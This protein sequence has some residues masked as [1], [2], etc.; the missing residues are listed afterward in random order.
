[1]NLGGPSES[2]SAKHQVGYTPDSDVIKPLSSGHLELL[3]NSQAKRLI[4]TPNLP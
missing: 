2:V 3:K 4:E 1:M